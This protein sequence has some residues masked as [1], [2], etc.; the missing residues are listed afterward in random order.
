VTVEDSTIQWDSQRSADLLNPTTQYADVFVNSPTD[1]TI[2]LNR[3]TARGTDSGAIVKV[4]GAGTPHLRFADSVLGLVFI[5]GFGSLD[6]RGCTLTA[7][8]GLVG[9][10][11]TTGPVNVDGGTIAGPLK[12][13][14][15]GRPFAARSSG[16]ARPR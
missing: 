9:S 13:Q 11:T 8:S 1:G 6:A 16:P 14:T 12:L 2:T 7:A 4:T 3:L 5:N 15:T 10:A